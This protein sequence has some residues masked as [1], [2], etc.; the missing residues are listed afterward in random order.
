MALDSFVDVEIYRDLSARAEI[1]TRDNPDPN[2]KL[3]PYQEIVVV[4]CCQPLRHTREE[5]EGTLRELLQSCLNALPPPS[6][7]R[8][9]PGPDSAENY[10]I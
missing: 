7:Y 5:I 10:S 1:H 8:Q 2:G 6:T 3:E 4:V 9:P